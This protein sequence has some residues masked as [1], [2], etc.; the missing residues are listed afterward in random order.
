MYKN[1]RRL[2]REKNVPVNELKSLLNLKTDAAYYKKERGA[3]KFSVEEAKII[4]EFF[5]MPIEIVFLKEK[6]I[7]NS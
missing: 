3:I 6:E 2:R 4:A 1:L 5:S 7:I